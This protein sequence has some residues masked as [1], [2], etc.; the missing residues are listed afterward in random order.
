MEKWTE[1]FDK[2]FP[3]P[4]FSQE[5]GTDFIV[6]TEFGIKPKD[7]KQFISD[8][9]AERD[10]DHE[11]LVNTILDTKNKEL[12]A[13]D[14]EWLSCLPEKKKVLYDGDSDFNACRE[15][16]LQNAWVKNLI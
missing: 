10:H 13:R 14:K 5:A 11:I 4:Y 7:I 9:L 1:Q 6:L 16:F 15:E 8:L 2:R 3:S 12:E